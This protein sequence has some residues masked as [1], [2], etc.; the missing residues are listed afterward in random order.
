MLPTMAS[1]NEILP[2]NRARGMLFIVSGPAGAGKGTI[3]N[4]LKQLV[5]GIH[6][7]ISATT[8]SPR[9]SEQNGIDYVFVSRDQFEKMIADNELLEWAEICGNFYGTPRA[10]IDQLLTG[11]Q[12]VLLEIDVQGAAQI[13]EM[14]PDAIMVFVMAPSLSELEQRLQNRGSDSAETIQNRI[15]LANRELQHVHDYDYLLI[16]SVIQT[17]VEDLKAIIQAEGCRV[18]R[19]KIEWFKTREGDS[20]GEK[21]FNGGAYENG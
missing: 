17:A 12:D 11:G 8:R 5:P 14:Y 1:K 16:N 2:I 15:A 9:R 20:S 21:T 19:Q 18:S 13:K 3:C 4:T 6:L 10:L 7:S